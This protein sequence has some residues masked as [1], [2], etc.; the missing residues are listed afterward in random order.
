MNATTI[1]RVAAIQIAAEV[2]DMEY[3][4]ELC[5][6]QVSRAAVE[7]ASWIVL[8][9]FFS[10]GVAFY[11]ELSLDAAPPDGAPTRLLC[12]LARRHGVHVGGSTLVRDDD[13]H[14]RNAFLLAGPD[15]GLVGRHDKDL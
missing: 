7:G 8:P 2:G 13:G 3:N 4:L 6:R 5:E 12:D 1:I 9:E 15:G 11:P 10:T 14:V